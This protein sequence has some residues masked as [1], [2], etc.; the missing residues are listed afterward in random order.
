MRVWRSV[1][2]CLFPLACAEHLAAFRIDQMHARAGGAGHRLIGRIVA[3][4]VGDK[5]LNILTGG[6]AA[7]NKGSHSFSNADRR[8]ASLR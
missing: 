5:A 2:V 6:R 1:R 4:I 7:V 3:W 8:E